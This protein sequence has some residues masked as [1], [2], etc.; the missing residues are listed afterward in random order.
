MPAFLEVVNMCQ[1]LHAIHTWFYSRLPTSQCLR[2]TLHRAIRLW[3]FHTLSKV[4]LLERGRIGTT[5]PEPG[6]IQTK[7]LRLSAVLFP[8]APQLI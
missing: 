1:A 3:G 8:S 6:S 7:Q 5:P 4:T 2:A